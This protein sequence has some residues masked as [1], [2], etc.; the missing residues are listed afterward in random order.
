MLDYSCPLWLGFT[1]FGCA[2]D[3]EKVRKTQK[4]QAHAQFNHFNLTIRRL[5]R[6]ALSLSQGCLLLLGLNVVRQP[7]R[8]LGRSRHFIQ[9]QK[10]KPRLAQPDTNKITFRLNHWCMRIIHLPNAFYTMTNENERKMKWPRPRHTTTLRYDWL[11]IIIWF[12][13]FGL[14]FIFNMTE[15]KNVGY[16]CMLGLTSV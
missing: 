1:V 5:L 16:Y 9:T 4:Y 14:R 3:Q 15:Q 10:A 7:A 11:W 8:T 13:I 2:G 6:L 12:G